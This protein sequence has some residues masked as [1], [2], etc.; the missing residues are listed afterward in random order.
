[1]NDGN[2]C[3]IMVFLSREEKQFLDNFSKIKYLACVLTLECVETGRVQL[4]KD[5]PVPYH[6]RHTEIQVKYRA[7]LQTV[8]P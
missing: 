2:M 6:L 7:F 8:L 5:I 4:Q 1:M 3:S